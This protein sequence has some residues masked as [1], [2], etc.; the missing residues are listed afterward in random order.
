MKFGIIGLNGRMGQEIRTLFEEDRHQLVF[1]YDKDGVIQSDIPD[2]LIDFSLP[3]VFQKTAEFVKK[4]QCPLVIG[5]TGLNEEQ[6]AMIKALSEKVAIVQSYNF[7]IGIQI[8][9]KATELLKEHIGDWDIE[10]MEIHH[11]FKQDKSSG[12]AKMLGKVFDRDIPISSLRLGNIPGDHSVY[13]GS[14][15]E[16]ITLSHRA[17]SRR[18]FAEGA[19]KSAKFLRKRKHGL[20]SF[21]QVLFSK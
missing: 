20:F 5:T 21:K 7:S 11:R 9:L 12:T 15:G 3:E 13:F 16:T 17:T 1:S 19:L 4:F 14:M 18:T 2:V 8:L 10:I 6:F